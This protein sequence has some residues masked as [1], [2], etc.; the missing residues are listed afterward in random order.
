MLKCISWQTSAI[1]RE[2]TSEPAQS[3]YSCHHLL[4]QQ[5]TDVCETGCVGTKC[6]SCKLCEILGTYMIISLHH[7]T[8]GVSRTC[9]AADRLHCR[10]ILQC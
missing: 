10:T 3:R 2:E 6:V 7:E 1:L 4:L 5:C 8:F 9:K